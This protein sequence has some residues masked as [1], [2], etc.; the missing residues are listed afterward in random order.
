MAQQSRWQRDKSGKRMM[1]DKIARREALGFSLAAFLFFSSS[2]RAEPGH[3][4]ADVREIIPQL[5][6]AHPRI[7]LTDAELDAAKITAKRDAVYARLIDRLIRE[8][9]IIVNEPVVRYGLSEGERPSML[10][11]SRAIIRHILYCAFAW[12]WTGERRFAARARA[13]MLAAANFPE[14]NH[15]HFLD[16]AE[17]AFGVALGY[18]WLHA[19]LTEDERA[20]IR[21]ALVEKALLWGDRAYRGSDDEWL[22]FPRYSWN[23][24]PVCNGGLIASALAV[25]ADEPLL[26]RDIIAGATASLSKALA[27]YGPDGGGGEG[28][29]YWTYGVLYY[30]L[31]SSMLEKALGSTMGL[32]GTEA[33]RNTDQYRL[34]VQ[35]PTGKAFNYGDCKEKIAGNVALAWLGQ[36]HAQAA[37]TALARKEML[38][39]LDAAKLDGEFDRF[40]PLYALW[41]PQDNKATKTSLPAAAHFRGDADIACFRSDWVDANAAYL[42]FKAGN[43]AA[44]HA[45]Q[46]I[47]SFV[48]EAQGIRWASDLGTDSYQLPGYF[49]SKAASGARYRIFRISTA[50]HSTIMPAGINQDPFA[51]APIARFGRRAASG[52]AIADLTA[53]YPGH[54]SSIRRGVNFMDAGRCVI[55]RDEIRGAAPGDRWR[56]ALL[57]EPEIVLEGS[58]ATLQIEGKSM[59]LSVSGKEHRF[60]AIEATPPSTAESRNAGFK[61]LTLYGVADAR[62]DLD[63]AVSLYPFGDEIEQRTASVRLEDWR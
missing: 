38:A 22:G 4:S 1:K 55:V 3:A 39:G 44:N 12:R 7:L 60:E 5:L 36:N 20:A 43:N 41:Y 40:F 24:N 6:T 56:W 45:H 59:R 34:W 58:R 21:M 35:G 15:T 23:W 32:I 16:V 47:G 53:A 10:G 33:F 63:L 57:T 2:S 54:A 62:G 30:V 19:F 26:A 49:D 29:V 9:E 8:A 48:L 37:T 14:W 50:S 31:N 25:A 27:A 18:D 17:T 42:G 11:G 61:L 13:E 28:P 52:Y 51:R 46:D